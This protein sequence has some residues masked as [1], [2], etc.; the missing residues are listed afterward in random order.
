MYYY[1]INHYG[2]VAVSPQLSCVCNFTPLHTSRVY[3]KQPTF[4][5]GCSW[6]RQLTSRH[7]GHLN[8]TLAQA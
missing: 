4:W 1:A 6:M 3:E 2:T 7:L 5:L 8:F